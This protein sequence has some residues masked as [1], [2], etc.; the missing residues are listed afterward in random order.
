MTANP[1]TS[2]PVE[3]LFPFGH[4]REDGEAS[5][6]QGRG[7]MSGGFPRLETEWTPALKDPGRAPGLKV[8]QQR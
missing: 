1:K 7:G 2:L 4:G 5:P 6:V 3:R 8:V